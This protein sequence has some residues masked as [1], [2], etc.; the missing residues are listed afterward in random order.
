M[1][2]FFKRASA[3]VGASPL[4]NMCPFIGVIIKMDHDIVEKFE[5]VHSQRQQDSRMAYC[6]TDQALF[7]VLVMFK[8]M[9]MF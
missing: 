6:T 2:F 9:F 5:E 8:K 7:T 1:K 4:I 3:M